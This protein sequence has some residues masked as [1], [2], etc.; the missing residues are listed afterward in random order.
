MGLGRQFEAGVVE[1]VTDPIGGRAAVS[2]LLRPGSELN[3]LIAA[4]VPAFFEDGA[5][6]GAHV[7]VGLH[8]DWNRSFGVLAEVAGDG[9][10]DDGGIDDGATSTAA[11]V[12]WER[13]VV[14]RVRACCS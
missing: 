1:L 2:W 7:G 9:G 4:G 13:S 6:V 14:V 3:P 8:C 11:R 5:K 10:V 12:N